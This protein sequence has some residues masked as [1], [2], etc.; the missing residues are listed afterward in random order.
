LSFFSKKGLEASLTGAKENLINASKR[1]SWDDRNDNRDDLPSAALTQFWIQSEDRTN[2]P[3]GEEILAVCARLEL[4]D[5][6]NRT[7]C[8]PTTARALPGQTK[9]VHKHQF[10]T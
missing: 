7:D 3:N 6:H 2:C 5:R 10:S 1:L 9:S 4:Q 8:F